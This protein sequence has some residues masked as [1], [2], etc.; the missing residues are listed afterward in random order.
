[1]SLAR[2][3]SVQIGSSFDLDQKRGRTWC[4]LNP[5]GSKSRLSNAS[6]G[7]V[8][9]EHKRLLQIV[10]SQ[11]TYIENIGIGLRERP[12]SLNTL[13]LSTDTVDRFNDIKWLRLKSSD[14]TLYEVYLQEVNDSYTRV[15]KVFEECA[16]DS[17][18][19]DSVSCI[20]PHTPNGNVHY[21]Q[22]ANKFLYP[23]D[24]ESTCS[25]MWEVS[26]LPHRHLDRAVFKDLSD[27]GNTVT[28]KFRLTRTLVDGSTVSILKRVLSRR[29]RD[30]NQVVIEWK[31][32]SEGEGVFDTLSSVT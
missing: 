21:T 27:D 11:N 26:N 17:M 15:D 4:S 3:G 31:I 13:Q 10:N 22:Y 7:R 18:P 9:A 5:S 19:I 12:S 16:I 8:E 6:N 30:S 28:F 14:A 32:F 20:H 2:A 25:G 24:F 23:L 29:F 1:M